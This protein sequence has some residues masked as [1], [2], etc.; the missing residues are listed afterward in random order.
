MCGTP[1]PFDLRFGKTNDI[2][3]ELAHLDNRDWLFTT[4]ERFAGRHDTLSAL[5][6]GQ[7]TTLGVP[8]KCFAAAGAD[9]AKVER[10]L[11]LETAAPLQLS[12][13]RIALGAINEAEQVL[14]CATSP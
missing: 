7:W 8:L 10:V 6:A 3:A 11:S 5:P 1:S 9:V 12:V 4:R 13:S 2:D 14:K